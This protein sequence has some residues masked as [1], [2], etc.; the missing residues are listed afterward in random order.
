MRTSK[1]ILGL[2]A[3]LASGAALAA[4]APH[5]DFQTPE[6]SHVCTFRGD[7]PGRTV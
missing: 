1:L 3:V 5:D 2:L 4:G 6:P 7:R